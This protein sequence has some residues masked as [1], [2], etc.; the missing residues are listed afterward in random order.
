MNQSAKRIGKPGFLVC[1]PYM[2]G[3]WLAIRLTRVPDDPE[4]YDGAP[5]AVQILGGRLEEEKLLVVGQ[6]VAEA[7]KSYH[8]SSKTDARLEVQ[9]SDPP[10]A[11]GRW[12]SHLS[13]LWGFFKQVP[14]NRGNKNV[15]RRVRKD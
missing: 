6:I 10:K 2:H 7:L 14:F 3:V 12:K 5:A 4:I 11:K 15:G 9:S 13:R 1:F 8:A